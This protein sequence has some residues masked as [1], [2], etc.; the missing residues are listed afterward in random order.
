MLVLQPVRQPSFPRG[1]KYSLAACRP[2]HLASATSWLHPRDAVASIRTWPPASEPHPG[3]AAA[4]R[5]SARPA[6]CLGVLAARTKITLSLA[7]RCSPIELHDR[8]R[9]RTK[10]S[11]AQRT[12]RARAARYPLRPG[13]R[14]QLRIS[15]LRL[16]SL[17]F[18]QTIK[19]RPM[20]EHVPGAG[21]VRSVNRG[22]MRSICR[23]FP[24]HCDP[25]GHGGL[26]AR[27]IIWPFGAAD[28]VGP[29]DR[30]S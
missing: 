5:L 30:A 3:G 24:T 19:A 6:G 17:G 7:I 10:S 14:R 20:R 9:G 15:R 29:R 28:V 18:L 21:Q 2:S 8:V 12:G 11:M 16:L 13:K 27:S 23:L 4:R 1:L 26:P 22:S 25:V